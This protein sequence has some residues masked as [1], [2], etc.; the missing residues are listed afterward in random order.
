MINYEIEFR[1]S[2]TAE[3]EELIA[4]ANKVLK[5][6]RKEEQREAVEKFVKAYNE[7]IEKCPDA[8]L[9]LEVECEFC[10][11][12][13]YYNIFEILSYITVSDVRW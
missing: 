6:R 2:S 9:E 8:E 11:Q 5:E 12:L 7:V 4:A 13:N 3:L 1:E 10:N